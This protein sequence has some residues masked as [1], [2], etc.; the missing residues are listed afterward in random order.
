MDL[1]PLL[2]GLPVAAA[3]LALC[4]LPFLANG[5][6]GELGT[7][8]LDDLWF[9][10]SQADVLRTDGTSMQ[11]LADGYPIGPHALVA[12]LAAGTGMGVDTAFT[13]LLLVTPVLLALVA[14]AAFEGVPW[15]LR[16]LG[17]SVV[18]IPYLV[19][20]YLAEGAFKEPLLALFFLGFALTL[21]EAV[22]AGRLERRTSP[23][24]R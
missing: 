2:A 4:A 14:L 24:L 3:V 10:M 15:P 19:A 12:T 9:H 17:A 11:V 13:G 23:P 16:M 5:R 21:R 18:G 22:R 6:I 8:V 20:S 1:R 7:S